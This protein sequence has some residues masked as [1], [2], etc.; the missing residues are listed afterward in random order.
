MIRNK[1]REEIKIMVEAG[2]KLRKVVNKLKKVLKSGITTNEINKKAEEL[3]LKE[4]GY[5]SFKRVKNY[6]WAICT[7][8]NEQIVHTPPSSRK[9]IK[10]D[11]LTVDI[12][13]EYKGYNVDYATS[14]L[15]EKKDKKIEHFLRVGRLALKKAIEKAII[16]NYLGHISQAIEEELKKNH[17]FVNRYLVG[18]GIGKELHEEPLVP[19]F[20]DKPINQTLKLTEGLA[21][22]IEVIYAMGSD[23]IAYE[24]NNSWSIV[25]KDKSLSAC[26]ETTI[27]ITKKE[28]LILV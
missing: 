24:K 14:C 3:I 8:I 13:L 1:T 15:I 19:G 5:P 16:G 12:G 11:L 20:L 6:C 4:G 18:H 9:L 2:K 28:P 22:A 26:F 10:G 21:L 25:T 7:P 17:Y 27:I 23:Q